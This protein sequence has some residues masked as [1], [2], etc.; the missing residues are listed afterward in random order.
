M[1][2]NFL[3]MQLQKQ[4][5]EMSAMLARAQDEGVK[6]SSKYAEQ[7]TKVDTLATELKEIGELTL[8]VFVLHHNHHHDHHH[9]HDGTLKCTV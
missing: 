3:Y 1:S 9:H 2:N 4:I 8:S 7:G 5:K 6:E